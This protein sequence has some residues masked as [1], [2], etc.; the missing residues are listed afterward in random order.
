LWLL[1]TYHQP[2]KLTYDKNKNRWKMSGGG[3]M[4]GYLRIFAQESIGRP[5]LE[6]DS[7]KRAI[8]G[9]IKKK[10][11]ELEPPEVKVALVMTNEKTEID[12]EIQDAPAVPVSAKKLKETIRKLS[13]EGGIA[14]L[15]L[16]ELQGAFGVEE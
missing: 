15:K 8:L 13:K 5:D 16:V 10:S 9:Y 11:P 12:E 2:G 1:K 4:Q 14:P 6:I 7:E 3:L